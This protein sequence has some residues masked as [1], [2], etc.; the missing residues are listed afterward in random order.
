[1]TQPVK[2]I[3]KLSEAPQPPVPLPPVV[4]DLEAYLKKHLAPAGRFA[5]RFRKAWESGKS[6]EVLNKVLEDGFGFKGLGE[7]PDGGKAV[8]LVQQGA[9]LWKRWL[10]EAWTDASAKLPSFPFASKPDT[11]SS[12]NEKG[13]GSS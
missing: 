5:E 2:Q 8:T 4:N 9:Q 1:M 12:S 6:L 3:T 11:K 10:K 13:T 7:M